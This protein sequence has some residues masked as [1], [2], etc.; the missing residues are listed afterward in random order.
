MAVALW[1]WEETHMT[2]LRRGGK[3]KVWHAVI[4]TF[5]NKS[6]APHSF[7]TS[8]HHTSIITMP[9]FLPCH[10]GLNRQKPNKKGSRGYCCSHAHTQ[11]TH[12]H[13]HRVV[14]ASD[15]SV[16]WLWMESLLWQLFSFRVPTMS[17]CTVLRSEITVSLLHPGHEDSIP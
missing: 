17:P 1:R 11:H 12:M 4:P 2:H 10:V 15:L 9:A 16:A 3:W 6:R 13:T 8:V 7:S 14:T 5:P